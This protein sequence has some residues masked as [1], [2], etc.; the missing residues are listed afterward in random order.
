MELKYLL[1]LLFSTAVLGQTELA[2][3]EDCEVCIKTLERFAKTLHGVT[4]DDYK[5]IE[6]EFK[7]FCNTQKNKERKFCYYLGGLKEST[8]NI[9]SE[10][11]KPL[12]RLLPADKICEKLNKID[13]QICDLRYEKQ[14][15]LK[16]VDLQKLKIKDL[17]Q[18]LYNWEDRCHGCLEKTDFIRRIEELIPSIAHEEL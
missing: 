16:N 10:L 11:S 2:L 17:K 13:A 7:K 6:T 9:L 12:S 8:R 5:M 4:R 15:D 3:K 18:I 1:L 14:L